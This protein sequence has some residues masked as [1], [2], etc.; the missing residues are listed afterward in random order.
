MA[1]L[2]LSR[3]QADLYA[4]ARQVRAEI[5]NGPNGATVCQAYAHLERAIQ[6]LREA[7]FQTKGGE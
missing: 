2:I 1:D 6:L 7:Q 5:D 4:I 3:L